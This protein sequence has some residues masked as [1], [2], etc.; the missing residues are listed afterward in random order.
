[1][2]DELLRY[3]SQF[4]ILD[5]TN[6]LISNSLGAM[7]RGVE[8]SLHHYTEVWKTRGVRAWEDE[9]WMLAAQVGDEIA[10][11]SGPNFGRSGG[12]ART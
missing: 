1:M 2:P 5:R 9:W 12:F 3:R 6:Y 8:D 4:P 11:I 7:P 10:G